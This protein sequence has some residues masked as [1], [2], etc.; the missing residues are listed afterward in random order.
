MYGIDGREDLIVGVR[1]DGGELHRV[2]GVAFGK[3]HASREISL[4][5]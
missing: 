4:E 5:K 3:G 2:T 1:T